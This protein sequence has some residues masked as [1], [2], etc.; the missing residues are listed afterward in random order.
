MRISW[1]G[2][3]ASQLV[4]D[5]GMRAALAGA[6]DIL[7]EAIPETPIISGT[8]RRSGMVTPGEDG[9]YISFDTPYAMRQHEDRSLKHTEPGTKAKY[10]EDPFNR[11]SDE[12]LRNIG[13]SIKE[14]LGGGG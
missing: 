5:A 10:L 3:L 4:R 14:A 13:K 1:K 11:M 9:A 6:E 12:V 2:D 7:T 8:L